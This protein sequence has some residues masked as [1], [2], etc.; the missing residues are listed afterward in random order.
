MASGFVLPL[1]GELVFNPAP[2][3]AGPGWVGSGQCL[4]QSG[5]RRE[6][7]PGGIY[8]GSGRG[9]DQ[10]TGGRRG[11]PVA[12]TGGLELEKKK[13]R[14]GLGSSSDRRRGWERVETSPVQRRVV[15]QQPPR[16]CTLVIPYDEPASIGLGFAAL[17]IQPDNHG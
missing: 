3:I 16:R 15:C 5:D 17:R 8:I 9:R 12:G 1:S 10:R 2:I 4:E 13:R 6:P 11:L 7:A 14:P